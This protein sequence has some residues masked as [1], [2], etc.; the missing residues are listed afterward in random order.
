MPVDRTLLTPSTFEGG[1]CISEYTPLDQPLL[2]YLLK[3]CEEKEAPLPVF[4]QS[5]QLLQRYMKTK[6]Q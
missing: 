2:A 3:I 4:C 5:L 1:M 6:N